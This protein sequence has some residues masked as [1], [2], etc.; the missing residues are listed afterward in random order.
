M[1]KH[2]CI[3]FIFLLSFSGFSQVEEVEPDDLIKTITFKSNTNQSELPILNLNE[4]L[5][6]EFDVLSPDEEDFYYVIE[7]YN[8]DWTKSK[9][10]KSE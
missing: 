5:T 7:H 4:R 2:L 1:L 10:I 3:I 8:F 9:L 6:L